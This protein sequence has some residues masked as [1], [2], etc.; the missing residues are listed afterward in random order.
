VG[1]G[2]YYETQLSGGAQVVQTQSSLSD[3]AAEVLPLIAC[4]GWLHWMVLALIACTDCLHW[5]CAAA[6]SPDAAHADSLLDSDRPSLQRI[7]RSVRLM[8]TL[9]L[10][11]PL[12]MLIFSLIVTLRSAGRA[13]GKRDGRNC[14]EI[15]AA[16]STI[17]TPSTHNPCN[18][19][20]NNPCTI[21]TPSCT[22]QS[23]H[24]PHTNPY[25]NPYART[26]TL[27]VL[28]LVCPTA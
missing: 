23:T 12:R 16:T 14:P 6:I 1:T 24:N 21:R 5:I 4:T 26:L 10:I 13:L 9:S 25:Y 22:H 3:R 15:G 19:P 20:C 27:T 17:R 7:S 8:L 18:N 28:V 2:G 11:R